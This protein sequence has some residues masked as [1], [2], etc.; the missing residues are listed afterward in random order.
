MP[1]EYCHH[2]A[3]R[4]LQGC[5]TKGTEAGAVVLEQSSLVRGAW[6]RL[7]ES[8]FQ[9]RCE[10]HQPTGRRR[11]GSVFWKVRP[12]SRMAKPTVLQGGGL[13]SDSLLTPPR[14]RWNVVGVQGSL[15]S[16]FVEPVY[17]SSIILGSLYHGDHLSRA[18]YQRIADIEGL[19]PLYVLNKPLLS[20]KLG[21]G[22]V[23]RELVRVDPGASHSGRGCLDS[24]WGQ[25]KSFS[26]RVRMGLSRLRAVPPSKG[27]SL[28]RLSS[29]VPWVCL[30]SQ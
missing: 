29:F 2:K 27:S 6:T 9:G 23:G 16:I 3:Q 13:E 25:R 1:K 21:D 22:E 26:G 11:A 28:L 4:V 20:G 7:R 14:P 8:A 18:M 5:I 12:S 19:P 30:V 17:F 10:V 15:L 24:V